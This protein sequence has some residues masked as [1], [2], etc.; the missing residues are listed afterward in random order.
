[1]TSNER[2]APSPAPSAPDQPDQ[3]SAPLPPR[4]RWRLL[5]VPATAVVA[6]AS[7]WAF[8]A[9]RFDLPILAGVPAWLYL[10]LLLW[11]VVR[12]R[13]PWRKLGS[14][15][16]LFLLVTAWWLTLQPSNS[17]PW[18]PD[19]ELLAWAE[20]DGDVATIHNVRNC[21]Y[22]SKTDYTVRYETRSYN[23]SQLTGVDLFIATWGSE[24]MAHPI[25]SFQF[26][27]S[28]AVCFSIETRKELQEEYS[29]LGG[30]YRRF[31]L[32]YIVADE[33]DVIRLRTNYRK[34]EPVYLY[35]ALSSGS[36][37]RNR[38]LEYLRAINY[39]RDHPHWYNAI[40]TNCTTSIRKQHP[41][42]ARIPWDW[43]ILAN[44]KMDELIYEQGAILNGGLP[45]EELKQKALI[46][47]TAQA[48]DDSPDFSRL[49][50]EGRPGF[51]PTDAA[52]P[53]AAP[54]APQ[55]Q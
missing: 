33:R 49:I 46:N 17:R 29:A 6:L 45:F 40:T 4:T 23:I 11:L 44:G 16:L 28:A 31:E 8:G 20:I 51:R 25:I 18:Q 39:L 35:R 47:E 34:G 55:T 37:I 19:V 14:T 12:I 2:I 10:L 53:G 30:L 5:L 22:Q 41:A 32:I 1:M 52:H 50:R 24:W 21:E 27:D 9:L 42:G 13:G 54:S 3:A 43:R 26:A 38:F 7:L 15:A 48:A 36:G